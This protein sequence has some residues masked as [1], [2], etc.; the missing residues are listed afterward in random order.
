MSINFNILTFTHKSEQIFQCSNFTSPSNPRQQIVK[1]STATI[2]VYW[3]I[4]RGK[5]V[6]NNEYASLPKMLAPPLPAKARPH[7]DILR[8]L[9][10]LPPGRII[11]RSSPRPPNRPDGRVTQHQSQVGTV[12]HGADRILPPSRLRQRAVLA[13]HDIQSLAI[14][15]ALYQNMP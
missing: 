15:V 2:P 9:N 6:Y 12:R 7:T 11:R 8:P 13:C 10:N 1:Y 5:G 3:F 4:I 14:V